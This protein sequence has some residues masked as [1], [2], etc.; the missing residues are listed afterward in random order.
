MVHWKNDEELIALIREQLYTSAIGDIMDKLGYLH[1]FLPP[2][3]RPLDSRMNLAGRAMP[4]LEADT[5]SDLLTNRCTHL[6][7]TPF[8]LMLEAL[9]DLKR[10][11][12]YVCSGSSPVYALWGELMSARAIKLGAAG[13]VVNGY[14]RDT[15]GILDLGIPVFSYG[16][17]AQ[18]QAPRG[19]VVDFR[20]PIQIEAVKISPGDM[21][22]GDT[23]GVCIVPRSVEKEVFSMALEKAQ[24][25][26]KVLQKIKEG[27]SA[28]EAFDKYG[29]M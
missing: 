9:D 22:V 5:N 28:K 7:D 23:D 26:R 16:C 14:S 8:G 1:Q 18:D 6:A 10:D 24:G 25:E 4:V 3:I 13:A 11:E 2:Q 15:T 29:I 20:I 12:V 17:Y 21:I 27:M 19:K